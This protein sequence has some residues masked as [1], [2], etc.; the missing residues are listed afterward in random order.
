MN[1]LSIMTDEE[2]KE[3]KALLKANVKYDK[4]HQEYNVNK[5]IQKKDTTDVLTQVCILYNNSIKKNNTVM[6]EPIQNQNNNTID[7]LSNQIKLLQNQV[8]FLTDQIRTKDKLIDSQ[9]VIAKQQQAP[10]PQQQDNDNNDNNDN[11]KIKD[12]VTYKLL[13]E[14]NIKLKKQ[15]EKQANILQRN[16]KDKNELGDRNEQLREQCGE[17]GR[18]IEQLEIQLDRH[19]IKKPKKQLSSFDL[20]EQ[21][22]DLKEF[23]SDED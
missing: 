4:K 8:E 6:A 22:D 21:F 2:I 17:L 10:P 15:V 7:I 1:N 12:S 14:E 18:K 16:M 9:L 20:L 23:E 19:G 5:K 3:I 13:E 11:P